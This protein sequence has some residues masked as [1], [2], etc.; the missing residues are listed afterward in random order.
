MDDIQMSAHVSDMDTWLDKHEPQPEFEPES[1]CPAC[2]DQISY[3]VG[4]GTIG[5]PEGAQILAQ[6]DEDDH[7]E[8]HSMADCR[9]EDGAP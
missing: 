9:I 1:R 4:H 7:S 3:C 2:G 8:C 5:D 6:H